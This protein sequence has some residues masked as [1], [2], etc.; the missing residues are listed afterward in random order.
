MAQPFDNHVKGF[1]SF[2]MLDEAT[3]KSLRSASL[4]NGRSSGIA[5]HLGDW[6][7]HA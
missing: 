3:P 4:I 5:D 6:Y 2:D 1:P 7:E